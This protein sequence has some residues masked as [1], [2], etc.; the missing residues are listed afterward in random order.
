LY[1]LLLRSKRGIISSAIDSTLNN[2]LEGIS[3]IE[4]MDVKD[5]IYYEQRIAN[6]VNPFSASILRQAEQAR[7]LLDENVVDFIASL[8]VNYRADKSFLER[9]VISR[10]PHVMHVPLAK[11]HSLPMSSHYVSLLKS[12]RTFREFL[13]EGVT[14]DLNK[15]IK[16]FVD[17]E[18]IQKILDALQEGSELPAPRLG[19]K[20]RIRGIS[21]ITGESFENRVHPILILLRL[22]QVSLF[23][24]SIH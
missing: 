14:T 8:P 10:H 16:D 24:N 7:P 15:N 4:L 5:K 1:D 19:W 18:R 3:E 12:D 17:V 9:F 11:K 23:L 6:Y 2:I 20:S 13:R 22:L 21:R